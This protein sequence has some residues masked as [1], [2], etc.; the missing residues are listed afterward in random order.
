MKK[1]IVTRGVCLFV[2]LFLLLAE[3]QSAHAQ[4]DIPGGDVS[5]TWSLSNSPYH[6]NGEITIPNGETLTIEPGIDVIFTGHYKFNV[7]G[8][9]LAVGTQLDTITFTA[10]DPEIGW[11]GIRFINTPNTND[12][13][14]IVYCSFKNGKANTGNGLDRS[15]GAILISRFDKVLV[16]NCLFDSNMNHGDPYSTGGPGIFIEYASPI[17]TNSTFSNN[18]GI[19]GAIACYYN[20]NAIISNNVFSNNKGRWGGAIACGISPNNSPVISGNM[21]S[22]NTAE[23]GGGV[24]L[25]WSSNALVIN[26]V[27]VRNHATGE[28]GGINC[29]DAGSQFIV[30]NTVA[31]KSAVYGGGIECDDNSDPIIINTIFYGNSAIVGNQVVISMNASDPSFLYCDIEGGKDQFGGSGAGVNYNGAYE[32]NVDSDPLFVDVANDDYHLSYASPCIGVGADSVEINGTWHYAPSADFEGNLRPNPA[33]SNPDIGALESKFGNPL[34]R[35]VEDEITSPSLAGNLLGDPATR[36]MMIYLPPSYDQGGNFPVVYLLHAIP[37]GETAY[38]IEENWLEWVGMLWSA[39]PDFPE[40]GFEGMLDDLIAESKMK[41]MIIV[42]PD[43]SCKYMLSYY[44]NSELNGNYE[45]YIVNDLVSYIDNHY[46][47]IPNRD[48][49]AIV[50]FCTGGY[51]A[52]KLAMKHQDVFGAAACHSGHLY[53]EGL[54]A[55][56]PAAIAENPDGMIGPHPERPVTNLIYAGSAAYSPN[57]NNPPFFVDLPFEY[58]SVTIID[59]VWNKWLEHDPFTMLSTYGADLASLRGVYFDCGDQDE[60]G[61]NY[62]AE[63]FHQALTAA[64]IGHEYEIFSGTHC[65]QLYSRLALSLSFI[66]DALVT[67]VEQGNKAELPSAFSLSQNYPNPFNPCTTIRYKLPEAA[68][69]TLTVYDLLGRDV[70]VLMN[71][72]KPLGAYELKFDATDLASGVYF[73]RM[74]IRPANGSQAGDYVET[75]K[76][77]LLR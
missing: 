2:T 59:S 37:V 26:N 73:Y 46:P 76:L 18:E 74:H 45:D 17:I 75:K 44:T 61:F 27:I 30:N 70:K 72:K 22:N 67:G 49:R 65:N 38:L 34:T 32:N 23:D 16:S 9:L 13:S 21:I 58:P 6:I 69:V 24:Y 54:K 29:E 62:H 40:N 43:A 39:G 1:L 8:R 31:Y 33:G 47:T 60:L 12:S 42:M 41:E 48:N 14:K 68:H 35:I 64:G 50:G 63:S 11:H 25:V 36:K 7:Q 19:T 3:T 55:M 52:I 10:E 71:E 51:G 57:L 15:G 28:G 5:G 20:S 53:F 56:I 77:I 66:S 4:T